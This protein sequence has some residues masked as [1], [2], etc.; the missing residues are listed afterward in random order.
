MP[1]V[2]LIMHRSYFPRL[3][4]YIG[5]FPIIFWH[6]VLAG[7]WWQHSLGWKM[8]QNEWVLPSFGVEQT[9]SARSKCRVKCLHSGPLLPSTD[10]SPPLHLFWHISVTFVW[11]SPIVH[12]YVLWNTSAFLKVK[13]VAFSLWNLLFFLSKTPRGQQDFQYLQDPGKSENIEFWV[14]YAE[15]VRPTF[16]W[17]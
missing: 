16:L 10:M 15:T 14:S 8:R 13:D 9:S 1:Y 3:L 6:S 12:A 2:S 11:H 17:P 5:I 7:R 4:C